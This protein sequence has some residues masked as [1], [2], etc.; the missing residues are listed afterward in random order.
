MNPII[1]WL[2]WCIAGLCIAIGLHRAE[3]APARVFLGALALPAW[4]VCIVVL[5][6]YTAYYALK[7]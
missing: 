4:A 2:C 1:L 5:I 3:H 6:G 7:A